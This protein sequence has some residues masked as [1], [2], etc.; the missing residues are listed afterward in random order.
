[1]SPAW[2]AYEGAAPL[3]RSARSFSERDVECP[4]SP[5]SEASVELKVLSDEFVRQDAG[6][7]G[8]F[9]ACESFF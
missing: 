3:C 6:R 7:R 8:N 9:T 2:G 1:V 5:P 4:P